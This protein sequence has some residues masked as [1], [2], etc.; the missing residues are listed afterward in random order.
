[1]FY[2]AWTGLAWGL[3][4]I[5]PEAENQASLLAAER[6]WGKQRLTGKEHEQ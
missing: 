2:K 3:G 4:G 6:E 5:E 1:M